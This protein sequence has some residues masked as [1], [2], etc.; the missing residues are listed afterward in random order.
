MVDHISNKAL[1]PAKREAACNAA[2]RC[3]SLSREE[4][5]APIADVFRSLA[6]DLLTVAEDGL[7]P[8][9]RAT[10]A[11]KLLALKVALEVQG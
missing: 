4:E 3:F 7:S 9:K 6:T 8:E 5:L 10:I 2:R 11:T 1:S